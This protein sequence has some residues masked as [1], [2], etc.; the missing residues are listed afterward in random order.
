[1]GTP[2][3]KP[4]TH[5]ISSTAPPPP[6]KEKEKSGWGQN[7][8][9]RPTQINTIQSRESFRPLCCSRLQL[10]TP[11]IHTYTPPPLFSLR[12]RKT[13]KRAK[14]YLHEKKKR[15]AVCMCCL[16]PSRQL[17]PS[18]KFRPSP[19]KLAIS[20]SEKKVRETLGFP[21]HPS[22]DVSLAWS[23]DDVASSRPGVRNT[24]ENTPGQAHLSFAYF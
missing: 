12:S 6:K 5:T 24:T 7:G 1:M 23:N 13:T 20:F 4:S 22:F 3:L 9:K 21:H 17:T 18:P 14:G 15:L 2:P 11:A 19:T 10:P 16:P 8:T